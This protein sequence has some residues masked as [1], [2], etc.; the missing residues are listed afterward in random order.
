MNWKEFAEGLNKSFDGIDSVELMKANV[1]EYLNIFKIKPRENAQYGEN[2]D[3]GKIH[4][5]YFNSYGQ[6]DTRINLDENMDDRFKTNQL[7]HYLAGVSAQFLTK[8]SKS[9]RDVVPH[10]VLST[11]ELEEEVESGDE[12]ESI[13]TM[14]P[15]ELHWFLDGKYLI[16]I[17]V[18]FIRSSKSICQPPPTIILKEKISNFFIFYRVHK[19]VTENITETDSIRYILV[20]EIPDKQLQRR[21]FNKKEIVKDLIEGQDYRQLNFRENLNLLTKPQLLEILNRKGKAAGVSNFLKQRL[22]DLVIET[23]NEPDLSDFE[24]EIRGKNNSQLKAMCDSRNIVYTSRAVRNYLLEILLDYQ[25]EQECVQQQEI[26]EPE[27]DHLDS[28][29]SDENQEFDDET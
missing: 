19:R 3:I 7:T 17:S 14:K 9:G 29:E 23:K 10:V 12:S 5:F 6:F 27:I 8:V 21:K 4:D 26:I 25:E 22:I 28:E 11:N 18:E 13:E 20:S 16:Q 1:D 24:I 15:G 2:N